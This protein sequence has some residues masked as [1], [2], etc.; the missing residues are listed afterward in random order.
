MVVTTHNHPD[1]TYDLPMLADQ[2]RQYNQQVEKKNRKYITYL[3]DEDS[4]GDHKDKLKGSHSPRN[5]PRHLRP[6]TSYSDVPKKFGVEFDVFATEHDNNLEHSVGLVISLRENDAVKYKIGITSDTRYM[7]IL[8]KL[9]EGCDVVVCHFSSL[10]LGEFGGKQQSPRRL[11]YTGTRKIIQKTKA[12]LFLI[13]EFW[14]GKG[15]IRFPVLKQLR[16]DKNDDNKVVI[17]G[18]IGFMLN[19][20]DGQVHCNRCGRWVPPEEINTPRPAR[21]YETLRYLCKDCIS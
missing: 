16:L 21:D 18:D 20:P 3:L 2:V 10:R 15:D 13:T 14:G 8:P 1:H 12:P 11:G 17:G 7:A 9:F 4:H 19:I 5:S 6:D